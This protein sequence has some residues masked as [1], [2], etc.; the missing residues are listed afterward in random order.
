M[1]AFWYLPRVH[2]GRVTE[3]AGY[4]TEIRPLVPRRQPKRFWS[5]IVLFAATA[6]LVNGLIGERGLME[7]VRARRA[8]AAAAHDLAR[9]RQQNAILRERVR[10]LSDD[11]SAI[12]DVARGDLGLLRTGEIVVTVHDLRK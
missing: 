11:P 12:E 9:L 10:R 7:T 4:E 6:L 3:T 1:I 5:H 8:Y 2:M